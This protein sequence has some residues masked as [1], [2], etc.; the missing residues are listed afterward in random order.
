METRCA[1]GATNSILLTASKL[2]FN[3][4]M[5][6]EQLIESNFTDDKICS[7]KPFH[8]ANYTTLEN[9]IIIIQ[10][11]QGG[12]TFKKNL[13]FITFYPYIIVLLPFLAAS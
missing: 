12:L 7:V 11:K 3:T 2:F 8:F 5:E 10:L 6:L 4:S 13:S 1:F 9:F